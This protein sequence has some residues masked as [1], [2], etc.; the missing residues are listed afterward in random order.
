MDIHRVQCAAGPNGFLEAESQ[1]A[2]YRQCGRYKDLVELGFG[3]LWYVPQTELVGYGVQEKRECPLPTFRRVF[4]LHNVRVVAQ[5]E[6]GVSVCSGRVTELRVNCRKLL[7]LGVAVRIEQV[8]Y[9]FGLVR[10]LGHLLSYDYWNEVVRN[11][12]R[13]VCSQR[14]AI[15]LRERAVPC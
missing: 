1:I 9:R 2:E 10:P 5:E 3:H 13:P 8:A 7:E 4:S 6:K 14:H 15:L 12:E 11:S